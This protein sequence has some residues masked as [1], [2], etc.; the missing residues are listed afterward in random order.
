MEHRVLANYKG[1]R[2]SIGS[3]FTTFYQET[4]KKFGP[5]KKLLSDVNPP[6][7]REMTMKEYGVYSLKKGLD[8]TSTLQHF[9]IWIVF[10][11]LNGGLQLMLNILGK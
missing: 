10:K 7:Y 11:L 1:P 6:K 2:I 4:S 3:F 8:G 9:K 5:I